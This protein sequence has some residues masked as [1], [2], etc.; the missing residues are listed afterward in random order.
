MA[1]IMGGKLGGWGSRSSVGRIR[2]KNKDPG[3]R[4]KIRRMKIRT[5]RG[6]QE[7]EQ[8]QEPGAG[9]RARIR[10]RRVE[11]SIRS[12]SVE[13]RSG[14]RSEMLGVRGGSRSQGWEQE[15][16]CQDHDDLSHVASPLCTGE[17]GTLDF[18]I[19]SVQFTLVSA[20]RVHL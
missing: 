12:R 7:Q 2:S 20:Y 3:A 5:I 8:E 16:N 19:H 13:V 15:Q 4:I 17:V 1:R 10:S 18:T 11:V 6:S 9:A 14:S